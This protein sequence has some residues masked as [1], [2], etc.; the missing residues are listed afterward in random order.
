[1]RITAIAAALCT[2]AALLAASVQG[3]VSVDAEL[4]R[5]ALAA[6]ERDRPERILVRG[7]D[8]PPPARPGWI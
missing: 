4:E 2:G 5:S 8:C 1:M 6:H 3:I 7:R